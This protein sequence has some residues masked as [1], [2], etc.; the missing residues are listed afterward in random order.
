[1]AI[2]NAVGLSRI[3]RVVGYKITKGNFNN[4]TP[5]LPQRIAILAE[6]N[7]ANQAGLS[8]DPV[9]INTLKQAAELYGYGS[10]IYSIMRILRPE[11]GGG[12]EGVPTIV[13]PQAEAVGAVPA[14][15]EV[16][17]TGTATG[18]GTHTLVI[19]GRDTVNGS[20]YDFN[21][22][23]GDT[24]AA[25][26][27]KMVDAV[28][29]VLGSPVG[30]TDETTKATLLTKWAGLT[31]EQLHVTV[32]TGGKPLG[33]SYAVVSSVT[34]SATPDI[35]PALLLF[36]SNW[37]T[38]VVNSYGEPSMDKLEAFNGVPDPDSPTGRYDAIV[39]KPFIALMGETSSLLDDYTDLT[40]N[41]EDEV[42]NSICPAPNSKGFK[43]EAAA[44][45]AVL[46]AK[47]TNDN[48]HLDT[49]AK[50]YPDMPVPA[51]GNIGDMAIYNNRDFLVKNGSSTVDL[52]NNKYQIMEL[53]TTY[54]PDGETPP[55]FRY[56]SD[57][58]IDLNVFFGYHLLEE[59]HVIDHAIA[60]DTDVVSVNNV[61]KPKQWKAVVK[62][63]ATDLA[64][65]GLIAEASFM[66]DSIEIG[67]S[68]SNPNRLETFF[69]YKR[70]SFAR[71]SS[72]TVEAGFNF[73][74][75]S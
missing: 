8:T 49:A 53:V 25:I 20:S 13:Y 26:V 27:A 40:A 34:G 65:R 12:V 72:T 31:S 2:S 22:V 10:P 16:T 41:R 37:N 52:V 75:L 9:E 19:N 56:C 6:A 23:E 29:G 33:V 61:I 3:S 58:M 59:I 60:A 55:Q 69:R 11:N 45:A 24:P 63:Y 48:P 1:M 71:I 14:E 54:R 15:R 68:T 51:N 21:I 67:L 66:Q 74:T 57:I 50:F 62:E 42:T 18:N 70:R 73:G 43:M 4:V 38:I 28:N 32:E 46:F 30:A 44:N 64:L 47:Q 35:D 5:N 7:T 17:P 39:I 36:G